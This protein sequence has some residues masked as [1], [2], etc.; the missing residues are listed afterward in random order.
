MVGLM[1][2]LC[3]SNAVYATDITVFGPAK[4]EQSP[5]LQ[6]LMFLPA[7]EECRRISDWVLPSMRWQVERGPS[8][9]SPARGLSIKSV[10]PTSALL[11][12]VLSDDGEGGE[13]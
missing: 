4:E 6:T 11:I 10:V 7:K 12:G 1:S 8:A 13:K 5:F 2:P 3:L 9:N